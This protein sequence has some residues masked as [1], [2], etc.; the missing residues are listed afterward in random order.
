MEPEV[1]RKIQ[2]VRDMLASQGYDGVMV[3]LQENLA[4]LTGGRFF[5]NVAAQSG[6]GTIWIGP[7]QVELIASNI[8]GERLWREE[9]A[10][11][12][13]DCLRLYPWH[14]EGERTKI[15]ASL[16]EGL[17]VTDDRR[18]AADFLQLRIRLSVEEQE[19]YAVL[20]K[21]AG[22][23]VG[24]VAKEFE[25]GET[26][27]QVAAR[28]ARASM[29][30]GME[31]IVCLVGADKRARAYR[32]PLPTNHVI[33]HY[34]LLVLSAR[35]WGLVASVSRAVHFGKIPPDLIS[36]Q[37]AVITVDAAFLAESRPGATLGEVFLAGTDAY[38][39]LG[40][41]NEWEYHHQGG[42]TGYQSRE[43]KATAH[44][45]LVISTGHAI[46][47]NPTIQGAKS[48]DTVLVTP[49]GLQI[50]TSTGNF[51]SQ[52]VKVGDLEFDRPLILER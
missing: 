37:Q 3:E 44:T 34:A 33:H 15:L 43:I 48:E 51:P 2:L 46:A 35:K 16:S 40:F 45:P 50:I 24:S 11:A 7:E 20:G 29:E 38:A 17:K 9:R 18:L 47:W 31:P 13:C 12:I 32:H 8:E 5:I 25:P 28:L 4:W 42:L 19:R 26:E 36:K 41:P 23:A 52:R 27:Y 21:L 39:R 14:A 10:G 6:S 30:R 49:N 22:E 1:K